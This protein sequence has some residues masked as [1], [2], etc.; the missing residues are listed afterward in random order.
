MAGVQAQMK[1]EVETKRKWSMRSKGGAASN[2]LQRKRNPAAARRL[3]AL[4]QRLVDSGSDLDLRPILQRLRAAAYSVGGVDFER[5]F[6][7]YDRDNS[8]Q[9]DFTEFRSALRRDAKLSV[10]TVSDDQVTHAPQQF[11]GLSQP[12]C[13]TSTH[14]PPAPAAAPGV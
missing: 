14:T 12:L 5:L 6:R 7:H 11:V 4:R 3:A 13:L 10:R 9:I 8:G 2:A 1:G